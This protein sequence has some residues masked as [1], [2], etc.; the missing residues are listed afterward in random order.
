MLGSRNLESCMLIQ[1][2]ACASDPRQ[3]PGA[4]A[5]LAG[6]CAGGGPQGPFLPRTPLG[7]FASRSISWLLPA[8]YSAKTSPSSTK[9]NAIHR[10]HVPHCCMNHTCES[11]AP[12]IGATFRH[13]ELV[14]IVARS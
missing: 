3:E 10:R 5:P 7:T 4:V 2:N 11:Q 8:K 9:T 14:R 1:N 13:A 12:S 6:I